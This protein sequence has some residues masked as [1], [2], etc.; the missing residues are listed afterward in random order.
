MSWRWMNEH[1]PSMEEDD[2]GESGGKSGEAQTIGEDEEDA[3]IDL[4]I[5]VI[6]V[7]VELEGVSVQD[8]GHIVRSPIL[9]KR[10]GRYEGE[11][12]GI[13]GV[14]PICNGE[15]DI[16]NEEETQHDIDNGKGWGGQ[17]ASQ[18]ACNT[19]PV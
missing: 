17:G 6:P 10:M 4:A 13:V 14:G 11:P 12:L 16:D 8:S 18:E 3:K 1:I 9:C 2:M 7:L 15:E 19:G 5:G